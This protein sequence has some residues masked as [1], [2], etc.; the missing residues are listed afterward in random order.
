MTANTLV[1]VVGHASSEVTRRQDRERWRS[2]ATVRG[3]RKALVPRRGDPRTV[4]IDRLRG[5][6]HRGLRDRRLYELACLDHPGAS[7]PLDAN[8]PSR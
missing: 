7:S 1:L 5:V 8:A 6:E 4:G 2:V 3:E